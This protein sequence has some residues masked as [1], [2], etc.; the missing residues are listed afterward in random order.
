[1]DIGGTFT[2]IVLY[3][4]EDNRFW[5]AKIS[6]DPVHPDKPF[7]EGIIKAMKKADLD[8]SNIKSLRH[9]TTIVTNALLEGQGA[10]TGLLVTEGFRDILEIGRQ[11]RPEL[12]D[13]NR[14]RPKPLVRRDFIL[15]VKERV[16][17]QGDVLVSPEEKE[18][19]ERLRELRDKEIDALAV[20]FLF[21]FLHPDHEEKIQAAAE[22]IL[23]IP[24]YLSH[25]ISPE[26]R[27]YERISTTVIAASV[28]PR[29][30]QYLRAILEHLK[31]EGWDRDNLALMHSGGGTVTPEEAQRHPHILVESGPA[32]GLIGA[33]A[34]AQ[35]LKLDRILAFDMGGTTAKAGL[36]R[37][38]EVEFTQEYEVGGDFHHGGRQ[39]GSGYPI[40]SPMIDVVECGAGAGSIAWIDQGGHLK[41]GP[42]SAGADPG[43]ACYGKG[44]DQP[45]V[46]DAY[47]LLGRLSSEGFLGGEMELDA[48]PALDAV[49]TNLCGPLDM[50]AED[51]ASGIV[52]IANINMLRILRVISVARGYDP[53]DFALLA[54]GGAG[55]LHAVELAEKLSVFHVV[56]PRF[57]GLFSS[58]G[59]LFAD[60]SM[61]F[62]ETVMTGLDDLDTIRQALSTLKKQAEEWFDNNQVESKDRKLVVT[63][64][65][66]YFHQNYELNI[67][68]P[69]FEWTKEEVSRIQDEFN[70]THKQ[71]YGHSVP[72]E[73]VQAVNIRVRAV[74]KMNKL[75]FPEISGSNQKPEKSGKRKVRFGKEWKETAV[76]ERDRLHAGQEI[77]GPAVIEE[78][79]STTLLG[80]GW[81]LKVDQW[82]HMHL[83][84]VRR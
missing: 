48:G 42:R 23:D 51:A 66:R 69:G 78:T 21:S 74:K 3:S 8:I 19:Q 79:E 75:R 1:V 39:R 54:Y 43:P 31:E 14:D 77:E 59:L 58:I 28:A 56:I 35:S 47:L 83:E 84:R 61:D 20:G 52:D 17:P 49:E 76:Y 13:L 33:E 45:T 50:K 41:V 67:E 24:V 27:E 63:G 25:R 44:G 40:R 34:L 64:D 73:P 71:T 4:E 7:I 55:P 62:V 38:G 6:S 30:I 26:F 5:K 65:L 81:R 57:P 11:Q 18:I 12:Y 29:V 36:I 15:E 10:R 32:A 37:N 80:P 70:K 2:D 60:M 72:G 68:L 46:T 82:G 9:G 16:S 22:K 53:R